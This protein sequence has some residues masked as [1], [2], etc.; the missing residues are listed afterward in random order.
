MNLFYELSYLKIL[1]SVIFILWWKFQAKIVNKMT[2]VLLDIFKIKNFTIDIIKDKAFWYP[3][4]DYMKC[5]KY[6][7]KME[8][9]FKFLFIYV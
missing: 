8:V 9:L 6:S 5:V 3:S 1:F 7:T 2:R 4:I